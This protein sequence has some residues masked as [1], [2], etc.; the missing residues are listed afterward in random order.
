[1]VGERTYRLKVILTVDMV[2]LA[3]LLHLY[4][5]YAPKTIWKCCWCCCSR[6]T[7]A[8]LSAYECC[9]RDDRRWREKESSVS[10]LIFV[11]CQGKRANT[12][13]KHRYH[14]Q[15]SQDVRNTHERTRASLGS[16]C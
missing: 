7:I 10:K 12:R 9:F 14:Q 15:V 3:R 5:V 8:D 4:N 1:V 13:H 16:A 6:E 11:I 2:A